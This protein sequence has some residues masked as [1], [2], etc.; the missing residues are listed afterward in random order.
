MQQPEFDSLDA[1]S[2][3]A[4]LALERGDYGRCQQLLAPLLEQHPA[5]SPFG[6]QLRLLLATAQMGQGN[7]AA[8]AATCRSLRACRDANLRSQ[9][10]D[11]QEVLEAPAL[12]RPREWSMTLPSLGEVQPLEG[13]VQA[14][15]R[16]RRRLP[17]PP[18]APPTGPT[19]APLGFAL[20]A[21]VL[22]LLTALLGGC[23]DVDTSLR[24]SAPGRLQISQTSQSSTGHP[25]PWQQQLASAVQSTPWKP[26]QDHGQLSLKA[27]ALPAQQ[28][29]DLLAATFAQGAALAAVDLPP[30]QFSLQER[31]WLLGVRQEFRCSLDLR[32]VQALPGLNLKLTLAPLP[33]RAIRKA[34]PLAVQALPAR[35][36]RPP[37]LVWQL[38]PGALNQ[39]E[40]SCW[41]WSRLG[42]GAVVIALL[43]GL[44]A[45]L[46]RLKLAA[47]FGLPQLPA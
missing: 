26:R 45:L 1:L 40:L 24:F 30:P 11:L 9:A 37:T 10:K 4:R 31:N 44:V 36:G 42:V 46:Q 33:Q 27:P 29:L 19:S 16:R 6:G 13:Q 47:G 34:E 22:L 21:V 8:A 43:L 41:R 35:Q 39:L 23:V 15:A 32:G 12:E 5:S 7:S 3:P 14:L 17:P 25:L 2:E 38:Q 28:A 20:V 18:P